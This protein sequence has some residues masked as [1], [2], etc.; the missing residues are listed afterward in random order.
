M[1]DAGLWCLLIAG[2]CVLLTMFFS[3]VHLALRH[4]S[5]VKLEEAFSDTGTPARTGIIRSRQSNLLFSTATM[6]L[7][8]NLGVLVCMA[9]YFVISREVENS[10]MFVPLLTAF[11]VSVFILSIFS[12]AIP[13][14]WSKYAGTGLLVHCYP[15]IRFLGWAG[16]PLTTVFSWIDPL[17]KRL[18]GISEDQANSRLDEKQEELLNVVEEREK[19]GVVDEEEREMIA[20]VLEFR[21]TTAGEIM[22]P[23]TEMSGI[24]ADTSLSEAVEIVIREGHSRY[25]VYKETID[26]ITG[27]LYAKDLLKELN[28]PDGSGNISHYLRKPFF[29]P[30]SK[31]LRSLLH[32]FQNQK[33]HVAV[34]LDEYGGTAGLVTIE[35]ILEELVGEIVD[36]YE[37]PQPEP[38]KKIDEYTIEV[39]A[40][41]E[42]DELNDELGIGVPEDEDYETIGGFVFAKLGHIP[43]TGETFEH[44]N[45]QFTV[46]DAG[47]RKINR[48]RIVITPPTEES[49]DKTS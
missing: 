33:V 35:D 5:W 25:P 16:W 47:E 29:V 38:I 39:D 40:R 4:I 30:E 1:E 15:A 34:V 44:E 18:A 28:Q 31:K 23:R 27:M 8:A 6:R 24:E 41:Y 17:I 14:A 2:A 12:V 46:I 26:N 11:A 9:G 3:A 45:L 19:E 48:L 7:L 13:H 49:Q 42:V 10:R 20:S 43:M 32:N 22:T 37:P 21:D 36:E